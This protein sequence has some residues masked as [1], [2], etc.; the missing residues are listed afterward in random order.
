MVV[1]GALGWR[2]VG[3]TLL[4]NLGGISLGLGMVSIPNTS[5]DSGLAWVAYVEERLY[6]RRVLGRL[7][8]VSAA[9]CVLGTERIMVPLCLLWI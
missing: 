3:H 7:L 1:S 8:H 5:G 2:G 9:W 4:H 6:A